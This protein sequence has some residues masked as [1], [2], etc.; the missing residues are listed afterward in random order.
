MLTVT[1]IHC[2]VLCWFS[3]YDWRRSR[4]QTVQRKAISCDSTTGDLIVSDSVGPGVF[5]SFLCSSG[6]E[7]ALFL[8]LL[9]LKQW[10]VSELKI[11]VAIVKRHKEHHFCMC[12]VGKRLRVVIADSQSGLVVTLQYSI[13]WAENTKLQI[14]TPLL[15]CPCG[16]GVPK[17]GNLPCLDAVKIAL[18]LLLQGKCSSHCLFS[19][20]SV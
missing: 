7:N 1:D 20:Y 9:K 12:P 15:L 5:G 13:C 14:L 8:I 2:S 19:A 4:K 10:W 11:L 16:L 18:L 3:W 17:L 6:K